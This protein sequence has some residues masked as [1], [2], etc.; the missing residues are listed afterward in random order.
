M[1]TK[2]LSKITGVPITTLLRWETTGLIDSVSFPFKDIFD[3]GTTP[4]TQW[5]WSNDTI[6]RIRIIKE[7]RQAGYRLKQIYD[8]FE[9]AKQSKKKPRYAISIFDGD[10]AIN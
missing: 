1:N 8:L 7:L 5:K 6:E 2:E 4:K 3:W 9:L 10:I